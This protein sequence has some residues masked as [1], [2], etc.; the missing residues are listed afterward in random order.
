MKKKKTIVEK[1]FQAWL[2]DLVMNKGDFLWLPYLRIIQVFKRGIRTSSSYHYQIT[3]GQNNIKWTSFTSEKL[4]LW[5]H[6]SKLGW[7]RNQNL[8]LLVY[9]ICYC[10]TLLSLNLISVPRFASI[11]L[12]GCVLIF[13]H[14]SPWTI[15]GIY[16]NTIS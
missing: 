8:E 11:L 13:D 15:L 6:K 1:S 9:S 12:K 4:N 5:Q 3:N 16:V 2:I 10:F 7:T 14:P